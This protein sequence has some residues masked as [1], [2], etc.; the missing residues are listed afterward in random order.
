MTVQED[1]FSDYFNLWDTT[2]KRESH[3]RILEFLVVSDRLSTEPIYNGIYI[4]QASIFLS[5]EEVE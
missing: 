3:K 4:L 2:F 1:S 5:S